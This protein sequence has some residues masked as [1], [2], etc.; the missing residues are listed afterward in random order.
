MTSDGPLHPLLA[1]LLS[2]LQTA[3]YPLA[4]LALLGLNLFIFVLGLFGGACLLRLSTGRRVSP[5]P[6]PLTARELAF[7]AATVVLN[8]LVTLV[9]LFLWRR[10]IIRF[11]S[12]CG[13]L[14][15][16]DVVV[17][18]VVMDGAMYVLHRVAHLPLLFRIL[19]AEHH[20]HRHPRP[21]T[22]F[23]LHPLETLGFG[24]LW[25]VVVSVYPASWLGMSVYLGL[26]VAFG[27]I[28][29]LGTEPVPAS[30]LRIPILRQ[31]ST[32]TFHAQHH[33]DP[34]HNY[35]FYLLVWDR[36]LGTLAPRYE[37]DFGRLRE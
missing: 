28:G 18:L 33:L 19:H 25:L 37:Q 36:L 22:L 21:L 14:A 3:P 35:G 15:W 27:V 17:L 12:D 13:L 32:S 2:F 6:P 30:F 11:R 31:I 23:V 1:Q 9:G 5:L 16:L 10:G 7:A 4:T 20:V 34:H 8:T 26:N 24:G 29:H